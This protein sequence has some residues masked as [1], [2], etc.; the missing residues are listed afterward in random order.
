MMGMS[1]GIPE[2]QEE[3]DCHL[4]VL[5]NRRLRAPECHQK[6]YGVACTV[7]SDPEK[8]LA[9]GRRLLPRGHGRLGT[10]KTPE[11]GMAGVGMTRAALGR[12]I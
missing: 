9:S 6:R 1:W 8:G 7:L 11:R 2:L 12:N 10:C 4:V 5:L 3:W